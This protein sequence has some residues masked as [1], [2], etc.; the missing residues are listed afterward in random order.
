VFLSGV[1][2]AWSYERTRSLLPAMAAHLANNAAVGVTL[3]WLL[4]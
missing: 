3:L 2:W 1:L 4:R